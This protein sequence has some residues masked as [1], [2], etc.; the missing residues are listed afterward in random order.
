MERRGCEPTP[1]LGLSRL[2][3]RRVCRL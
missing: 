1:N 2:P 3:E